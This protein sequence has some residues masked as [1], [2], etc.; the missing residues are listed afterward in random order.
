MPPKI[1]QNACILKL[2]RIRSQF[3]RLTLPF[4]IPIIKSAE[5]NG[6]NAP[7]INVIILKSSGSKT[8]PIIHIDQLIRKVRMK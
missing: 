1:Y 8:Y 6:P 3:L 5:Q 2:K 4:E 7:I